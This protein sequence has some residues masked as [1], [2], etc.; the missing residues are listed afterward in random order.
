MMENDLVLRIPHALGAAEAKRRIAGGVDTARAQYASMLKGSEA[1][2]SGNRMTFRITALAQ[3]VRG[4]VDVE[5]NFVELRAQLPLIIRLLAK[6]FAPVV[7]TTG[8]K[9]LR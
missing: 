2:W 9:L 8:R 4:S 5:D 7:E 1:D 3:T 6:R